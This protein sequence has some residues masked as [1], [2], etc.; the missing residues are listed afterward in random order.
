M[1]QLAAFVGHS[2]SEQ[3]KQVVREF[4]DFFDRVAKMGIGFSWEHAEPAAPEVLSRKVLRLLEGKNIFIG[5]CT[6]KEH[7]I[8]H[9]NLK[10]ALLKKDTLKGN[11]L[12]FKW[13]T[14]DWII[15][16]IGVA[17][18]RNMPLILLLEDGVE[19]PGGLQGNLE[20]IPFQ[21]SE[22]SKAFPKILE[23]LTSL[24]P[25]AIPGVSTAEE[26][27]QTETREGTTEKAP[28]KP[29]EQWT[30]KDFEHALF[31]AIH[32]D[33]KNKEE[34]LIQSYSSICGK[35]EEET[36][37]F[38]GLSLRYRQML[39]KGTQIQRLEE[40]SR[41]YPA[42]R[43]LGYYLA[44]S[45][46]EYEDFQKAAELFQKC[47]QIEDTDAKKVLRLCTAALARTK[48]GLI[49]TEEWLLERLKEYSLSASNAE[50]TILKTFKEIAEFKEDSEK[51]FAY[52][53]AFLELRPDDNDARFSIAHSYSEQKRNDLALLHYL[54]IPYHKRNATTW[55]NIGVAYARLGIQ[56]NAVTAYRKSEELGGTLA[57]SNMAHAFL[58]AGFLPEAQELCDKAVKISDYDK[59]IG[60]AIARINELPNEEQEK[61]K[62]TLKKIEKTRQFYIELGKASTRPTIRQ[63]KSTW[64]EGECD[65]AVMID[66]RKFF[67]KGTYEKEEIPSA[68]LLL[69]TIPNQSA[70]KIKMVIQYKGTVTGHT[71]TIHKIVSKEGETYSLMNTPTQLGFIVIA[72]DLTTAT[73]YLKNDT[74]PEIYTL[75]AS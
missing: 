8:Q 5:I 11:K 20:Y 21:R 32:S 31:L 26:G 39:G 63:Y 28:Q 30:Q 4:L 17:I 48:A 23:M 34:E 38:E 75:T 71:A 64:R 16:E 52:S 6:A 67:A 45:Y 50:P 41:A 15:Q 60:T 1:S 56:A 10:R 37:S 51:S 22:N 9:G 70:K 27:P 58:A 36:A 18:G 42:N 53:E 69:G 59:Q 54:L 62:Q 40:L 43:D 13:K 49:D 14:S 44:R 57:M 46:E 73:V 7:V 33:N 61:I 19:V 55:N 47:A 66:G 35:S 24:K 3:D 25:L 65:L 68:L 74:E 12:D 72:E 2:F 29:I